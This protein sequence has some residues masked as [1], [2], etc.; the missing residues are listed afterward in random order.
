MGR[1]HNSIHKTIQRATS[2]SPVIQEH[3][4]D[5]FLSVMGTRRGARRPE[6]EYQHKPYIETDDKGTIRYY[7]YEGGPL[8]REDGPA[9]ER[10]NG[11][12]EWYVN[13]ELHREDGPAIEHAN[14]D[15]MWYV[16]GRLHRE[17]GPALERVDGSKHWYLYGQLHRENGPAV[18]F[19]NGRKEWWLRG[20]KLTQAAYLQQLKVLEAPKTRF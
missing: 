18:E 2:S 10:V 11:D 3:S 14:G 16:N 6:A 1:G 9:V 13:G 19:A 15:K 12:L 7:L 17:D 20:H 5:S 8:H 4:A